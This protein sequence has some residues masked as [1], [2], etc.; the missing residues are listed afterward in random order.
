MALPMQSK[1]GTTPSRSIA[2]QLAGPSESGKDLVDDQHDPEFVANR[3]AGRQIP[4]RR[5]DASRASLNRFDDQRRDRR[6]AS[7]R[8][9][10]RR[11]RAPRRVVARSR[12][13]RAAALAWS[14]CGKRIAE[15]LDAADGERSEREPVVGAAIRSE[16]R[17][18]GREHRGLQRGLDCFRTRR[19]EEEAV[20]LPRARPGEPFEERTRISVG[21]TSP[22]PCT[23]RC[24]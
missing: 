3:R 5:D 13:S 20:E 12:E 8:G 10:S 16:V 6:R 22:I 21:C 9:A 23:R 11:R 7:E 18:A 14:A 19:C 2:N 17:L 1:S 4:R 24:A 15:T